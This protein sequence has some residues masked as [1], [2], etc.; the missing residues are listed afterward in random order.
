MPEAYLSE[1]ALN[2]LKEKPYLVAGHPSTVGAPCPK[3][4]KY[5]LRQWSFV[6]S[7]N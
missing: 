3:T 6:G 4:S 2:I 5:Y 1:M 7:D